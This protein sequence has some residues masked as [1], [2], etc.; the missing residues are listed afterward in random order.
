VRSRTNLV[1]GDDQAWVP[2]KT[3]AGFI[4]E[5]G[6][7]AE[8]GTA[9]FIARDERRD[10]GVEIWY[11]QQ[12]EADLTSPVNTPVIPIESLQ[13]GD[14][15]DHTC[16]VEDTST[17][18]K[19][20]IS[21]PPLPIVPWQAP[22]DEQQPQN[23]SDADSHLDDVTTKS[24]HLSVIVK[25]YSSPAP[26]SDMTRRHESGRR[27]TWDTSEYG[28][29]VK[30]SVQCSPATASTQTPDKMDTAPMVLLDR[31]AFLM[32]H[33]TQKLAP[34]MDCCDPARHFAQEV[35]RRA[36]YTNV[37][38]YAVLALS[39][40]HLSLTDGGDTVEASFYHGRCMELMT[41]LLSN[42]ATFY[43]DNLVATLVCMR[44]YEELD[45]KA[46]NFIH[47]QGI[48]RLLHAVP[49]FAHSGG[50]AE[51]ASWQALRQD[52]YVAVRNETQPSFDL[53]AYNTSQAFEFRDDASC[54]KAITLIFGRLLRLTYSPT[55]PM[56]LDVW[57]ELE[58]HVEL[59]NTQRS[60]IFRPLFMKDANVN[61]NQPFPIIRLINPAQVVALQYRSACIVLLRQHRLRDHAVGSF[62]AVKERRIAERELIAALGNV[63]G[64]AESNAWVGNANFTAHHMLRS[65]AYTAI[66]ISEREFC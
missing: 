10:E 40:R 9:D 13:V 53:D 33:F 66:S 29:L 63:I 15:D 55:Q 41:F 64:L 47:L 42:P 17:V 50:L 45:E 32:Q 52:I 46:D 61:E 35:P 2:T 43:D 36:L 25:D 6:A 51:A 49:T 65:S 48:G 14:I 3:A 5:D 57:K 8:Y 31:D 16:A 24:A 58:H 22:L 27:L 26:L 4:L 20:I 23:P 11:P 62:E 30:D 56:P 7:G 60:R 28:Y 39:S 59:W 34:W 1:Y 44:T 54:A 37:L 21:H 19:S 12:P 18:G 38:L